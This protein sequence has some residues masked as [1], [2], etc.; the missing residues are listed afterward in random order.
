VEEREATDVGER[1]GSAGSFQ[2]PLDRD[3]VDDAALVGQL[4]DGP[5]DGAVRGPVEVVGGQ[6]R[7]GVG[8]AAQ[9][10]AQDLLLGVDVVRWGPD[11]GDVAA[12]GY[13]GVAFLSRRC[14][15][16]SRRLP[17]PAAPLAST[18]HRYH[19]PLRR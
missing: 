12:I 17:K 10:G 18:G 16:W 14:W 15:C 2:L 19:R 9:G 13:P 1:V 5:V 11:L 7:E 8:V 6:R 3:G 4:A